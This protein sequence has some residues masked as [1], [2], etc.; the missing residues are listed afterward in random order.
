MLAQQNI[1][2]SL[3]LINEESKYIESIEAFKNKALSKAILKEPNKIYMMNNKYFAKV[4]K[5]R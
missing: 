3:C 4:F 2:N 1:D 5:K